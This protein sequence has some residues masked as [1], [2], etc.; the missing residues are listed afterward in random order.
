MATVKP[1]NLAGVMDRV[2]DIR[3]DVWPSKFEVVDEEGIFR[4]LHYIPVKARK[5]RTPILMVYAFINRPYILDLR[6]DI[7]VVDKYLNAGFDVYMIDWGYPTGADR[8][9]NLDDYI[10]FLDKSVENIKKRNEVDQV[11]VHGYCLGGTLSTAYAAIRPRNLRSLLLQATPIDFNTNNTLAVWAR[12]LDP[13][14]V[15][16][17]QGVATGA[18]LNAGFL[19]VDP[20]NLI[21]GKYETFLETLDSDEAMTSFLCMDRWIF[22]SPAIPGD[23]FR[24]YIRQWYQQNLLVRGQFQAL[25][26]AVDLKN[27]G[28]PL[29]VLSA[30]YDHIAPPEST[31]VLL[32]LVSSR[33]KEEFSVG[34][35]HI[36]ITTSPTLHREFWPKVVGWMEEHSERIPAR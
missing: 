5:Y 8:Y 28:C 31:R 16:E 24:Q 29:L 21:A 23:A 25:G 10:D 4:L 13:D 32:D 27:I 6:K 17:A 2:C 30:Q 3:T 22:D 12:S 19:L 18:F 26:E 7:S 11:T 20:M 9:L 33:D 14:K 1:A 35:G 36:G 15:V 34:K